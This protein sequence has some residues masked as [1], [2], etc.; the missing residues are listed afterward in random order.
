MS[1]RRRG[2][3]TMDDVTSPEMGR[4]QRLPS[5]LT[6]AVAYCGIPALLRGPSRP[7]TAS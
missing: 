3:F 5:N 4:G 2:V 1:E 6:D 7:R